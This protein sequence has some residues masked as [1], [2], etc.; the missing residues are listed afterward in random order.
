MTTLSWVGLA[1]RP[2]ARMTRHLARACC[3]FA[4]A[5]SFGVSAQQD[6]FV[7]QDAGSTRQ[8]VARFVTQAGNQ[9]IS[10]VA[11]NQTAG[12]KTWICRGASRAARIACRDDAAATEATAPSAVDAI[13]G[14]RCA[15]TRTGW[16]GVSPAYP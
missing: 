9:M 15:F 4:A 16:P 2:Q 5:A 14:R 1:A 6:T 12:V 8:Y 3:C 10:F 7:E 13:A 11:G